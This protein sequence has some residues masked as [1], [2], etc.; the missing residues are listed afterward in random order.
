MG[1]SHKRYKNTSYPEE[2]EGNTK[3][4][5]KKLKTEIKNL[6]KIIK[7]LE[8]ENRTLTRSFNK[9]CDYINNR[10][11]DKKIEQIIEM[12]NEF[13]QQEVEDKKRK[14]E[15]NKK[16]KKLAEEKEC[17]K[18]FMP[19]GRGYKIIDFNT[20]KVHTCVCGHR[21]RINDEN[22]GIERSQNTEK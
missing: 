11:S 2:K 18:C 7:N 22:E 20:F 10:L 6:K 15:V 13:D 19:E 14:E 9:S 5:N 1:R 3:D 8:S 16:E 17:P 12:I 4:A 21:A